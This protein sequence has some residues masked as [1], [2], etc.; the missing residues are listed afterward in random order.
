MEAMDTSTE[1]EVV[2][3]PPEA[4]GEEVENVDADKSEVDKQQADQTDVVLSRDELD[5]LS[6]EELVEICLK[7]DAY[8]DELKTK[9]ENS[10][11]NEEFAKKCEE[12]EQNFVNKFKQQQL[13]AI[14]KE[15]ILFMRLTLKEQELQDCLVCSKMFHS[16]TDLIF[17]SRHK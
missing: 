16:L 2:P 7:K 17:F 10:K 8:I 9:L 1:P 12:I 15:N 11:S 3:P 5:N 4:N 13:E 6:A 14:R